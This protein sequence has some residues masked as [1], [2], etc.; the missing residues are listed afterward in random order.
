[1]I[2]SLC[3]QSPHMHD[4]IHVNSRYY[5]FK[6]K[7]KL[8][9]VDFLMHRVCVCVCLCTDMCSAGISILSCESGMSR[10]CRL[11]NLVHAREGILMW[12]VLAARATLHHRIGVKRVCAV[13]VCA[14]A[15]ACN[16]LL[17][18]TLTTAFSP[19][20]II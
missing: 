4:N 11:Q 5:D 16:E 3:V 9:V 18:R 2:W 13:C 8:C 10:M 1:M 14:S 19:F 15:C 6:L 20:Y 7:L 17:M 12:S